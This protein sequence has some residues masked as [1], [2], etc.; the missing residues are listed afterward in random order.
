MPM[1][2]APGCANSGRQCGSALPLPSSV[3]RRSCCRPFPAWRSSASI[4]WPASSPR[5]WPLLRLPLGA[6]LIVACALVWQHRHGL[7]NTELSSLSPVPQAEQDLDARLRAD[8]GAPDV[9][10][11]VSVSADSREA[12]LIASERIARQ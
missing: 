11:L 7:W 6:L 8:L 2:G 9:R 10:Y 12:A 3:S 1:Q 4:R 5:R